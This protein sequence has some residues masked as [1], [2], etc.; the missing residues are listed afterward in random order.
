MRAERLLR[1]PPP[2][3]RKL[4]TAYH[5]DFSIHVQQL[6]GWEQAIAEM[7]RDWLDADEQVEAR[8]AI[9]TLLD[10]ATPSDLKGLLKRHSGGGP[11]LDTNGARRMFEIWAE[12]LE[13]SR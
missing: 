3:L 1:D 8:D 2:G 11:R 7:P 4:L 6:G 9:C 10:S 13:G 12:A 5:Q